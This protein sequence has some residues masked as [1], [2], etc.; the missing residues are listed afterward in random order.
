MYVFHGNTLD[1]YGRAAGFSIEPIS[2]ELNSLVSQTN[3]MKSACGFI[4]DFCD[5]ESNVRCEQTFL[6]FRYT[7]FL[8]N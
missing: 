3:G 4:N 8:V 1:L 5:Y 6:H 2:S 7:N